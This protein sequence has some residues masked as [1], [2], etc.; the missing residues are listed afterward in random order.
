MVNFS[1]ILV[2][3][4]TTLSQRWTKTEVKA[5]VKPFTTFFIPQIKILSYLPDGTSDLWITKFH[6][7][8][9]LRQR[10]NSKEVAQ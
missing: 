8:H 7:A 6:I 1:N 9:L 4:K 5:K 2:P 3:N 10:Y